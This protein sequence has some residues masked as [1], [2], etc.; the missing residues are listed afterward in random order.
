[1][2]ELLHTISGFIAEH[3]HLAYLAVFLLALSESLPVIGALVPG[4]AVIVAVSALVPGGTLKL[5]PL[6]LSAF[7]GA[8]IGDGLAFWLGHRSHRAVL[9][10]WPLNRQPELVAR[11]EAFFTRHGDK[12]VFIARFTPG[13]RAV[14]PLFAGILR[15]SARRFYLADFLSALIWAP[16]HILPGVLVG[17]SL[18]RLGAEVEPLAIL[19]L[20]LVVVVW[21]LSHAVRLAIRHGYPVAERWI[22]WLRR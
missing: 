7:I 9:S 16:A 1:M 10:R 21:L 2:S 15:M 22:E 11:S 5:W 3:P 19:A 8:I 14:V 6:L 13:M 17:A 20:L 4:S 12:S 18:G